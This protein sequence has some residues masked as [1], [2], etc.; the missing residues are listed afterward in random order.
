MEIVEINRYVLCILMVYLIYTV[1]MVNKK[2]DVE[3]NIKK[4]ELENVGL[5]KQIKKLDLKLN[6]AL[7]KKVNK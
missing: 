4:Q 6:E 5:D 1:F 3:I 7:L 2:I